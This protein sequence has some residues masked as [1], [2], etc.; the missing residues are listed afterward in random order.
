MKTTNTWYYKICE[1]IQL[2]TNF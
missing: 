2:H 1:I